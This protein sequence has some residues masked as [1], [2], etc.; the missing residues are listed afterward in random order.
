MRRNMNVLASAGAREFAFLLKKSHLFETHRL[1]DLHMCLPHSCDDFLLDPNTIDWDSY[2]KLYCYGLVSIMGISSK[3]RESNFQLLR[4]NSDCH[5]RMIIQNPWTYNKYYNIMWYRRECQFLIP[6]DEICYKIMNNNKVKLLIREIAQERLNENLLK[7]E[8]TKNIK[9][10]NILERERENNEHTH[11][12]THTHTLE[13]HIKSI[14]KESAS[15]LKDMATVNS[16]WKFRIV[17]LTATKVFRD[18]FESI[19][20]N[21]DALINLIE[22]DKTH[23]LPIILL[24]SHRSYCDFVLLSYVMLTVHH[25]MPTIAAGDDFLKVKIVHH[26][27]RASG[28]FFMR[29]FLKSAGRLYTLLF[30]LYFQAVVKQHGFVELFLE[31][32]R[33]RTGLYLPPKTGLLAMVLELIYSGE[34][35]DVL[36]VPIS[37]NYDRVTEIESFPGELLGENKVKESLGR[38]LSGSR[39][40]GSLSFGKVFVRFSNPIYARHFITNYY[41]SPHTHIHTHTHTHIHMLSGKE[42]SHIVIEDM[43]EAM[44]KEIVAQLC[45]R[46]LLNIRLITVIRP[47]QLVASI[48]GTHRS[49]IHLEDLCV[50][51]CALQ[52]ELQSM[53]CKCVVLQYR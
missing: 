34:V 44:K 28:A 26:L 52:N 36:L 50:C 31:G 53:V 17:A 25:R 18:M 6:P 35:P 24:P 22:L 2:L 20:V 14:E 51:V 15:I 23:K 43:S 40:F 41:A 21:Y 37:I 16:N 4:V 32:T 27:L 29:R 12:H 30:K 39:Q 13:F 42:E 19:D 48:V 45:E 49:G 11:T 8:K 10:I 46:V 9:N 3:D 5:Q 1:K 7:K 47:V 33:T 38:L